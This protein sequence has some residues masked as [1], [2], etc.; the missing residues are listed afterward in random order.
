MRRV[1]AKRDMPE[2]RLRGKCCLEAL[3]TNIDD[4]NP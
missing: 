2:P 1:D 3:F 4:G